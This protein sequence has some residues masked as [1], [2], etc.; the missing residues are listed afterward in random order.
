MLIL[1]SLFDYIFLA[2][3]DE[4]VVGGSSLHKIRES[5]SFGNAEREKADRFG[6]AREFWKMLFNNVLE[7]T[8][9]ERVGGIRASSDSRFDSFATC[10][11]L[12][13]LIWSCNRRSFISSAQQAMVQCHKLRARSRHH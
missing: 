10:T 9:T 4:N 5:S 12:S 1:L 8:S 3:S 7:L 13:L 11:Q 6:V 2:E